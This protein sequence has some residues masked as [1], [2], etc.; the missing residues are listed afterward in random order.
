M[1]LNLLGETFPTTVNGPGNRYMIHFQG[2]PLGCAGCFNPESW[3][4][5]EK[6]LVNIYGLASKIKSHNPDGLT[7]SGGEPFSNPIGLLELLKTLHKDNFFFPKG[8]LIYSGYYENELNKIQEYEEILNFVCVI[9]SGRYDETKRIYN[10]LLSSSN[11]KFI[12][13]KNPRITEEELQHQDFEVIIED[14]NLKLTGFPDLSKES[15][16]LLKEIGV[17]IKV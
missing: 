15:R 7:I 1:Q 14:D 11:Q 12:W 8:V 3:S 5:K 16:K 4:F 6:N 9:V 2:C 13:G 10:S 17:D